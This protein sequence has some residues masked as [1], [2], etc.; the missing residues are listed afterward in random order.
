MKVLHWI[1]FTLI[2]KII[3]AE[4]KLNSW[5]SSYQDRLLWDII[6][7]GTHDT[8]AFKYAIPFPEYMTDWSR[9]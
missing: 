3:L 5:M 8:A 7:P 1:S 4:R 2:L 6:L 9:T